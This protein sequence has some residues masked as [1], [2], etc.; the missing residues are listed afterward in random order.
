MT[1]APLDLNSPAKVQLVRIAPLH[2]GQR[3]DNYLIREL[4][5]VPRSRI[6]RFI[7]RGEV[8]VNKKRAKPEQRLRA[9]DQVRVPP[10]AG[11][12]RPDPGPPREG[13]R[14]LLLQAIVEDK[15]DYL[16]LN[17]PAG[18]AVHG[19]SGI[20]LGM[21]EAVR[22][23]RPEWAHTELAHRLDR[24]TS[25]CL[26]I[27]KNP[28]YLKYLQEQ[29]KQRHV[30]KTYLA[31][32]HGEWPENM[33]RVQLPL[34]KN[35]L[36]S[37]ERRLVMVDPAGKAADTGFRVLER[38]PG[39]TLLEVKPHTGR[40]HQIRVHC[41]HAG[42]PVVGDDRY[43]QPRDKGRVRLVDSSRHLCLHAWKIAFTEA[44]GGP[45]VSF[46]AAPDTHFAGLLEQLRD[47]P[48]NYR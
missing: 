11:A 35:P 2:D 47:M 41:Q 18:L 13:L 33:T 14:K 27:A 10:F 32:V 39:A 28:K 15:Q 44:P 26:V 4:K 36:D 31:L 6:Y 20:R 48:G 21:I 24:D 23:L 40:T 12:D 43:A 7:R 25:G 16:V 19:G 46:E 8:R 30:L 45:E 42:H 5:G 17:K 3:L 37:G 34:R 29:F 22:K 38:L 9:G 1:L